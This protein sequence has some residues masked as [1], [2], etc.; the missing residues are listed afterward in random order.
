[1]CNGS[2]GPPMSSTRPKLPRGVDIFL[3]SELMLPMFLQPSLQGLGC[4]QHPSSASVYPWGPLLEKKQ[5]FPCWGGGDGARSRRVQEIAAHS[6][7]LSHVWRPLV[8]GWLPGL[9]AASD[10]SDAR[11][12]IEMHCMLQICLFPRKVQGKLPRTFPFRVMPLHSFL[13]AFKL[14]GGQ[15]G[16]WEFA[17]MH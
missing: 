17:F 8:P 14:E 5:L 9:Q 1:M 3:T 11:L 7:P 4:P 2:S 13:E 6:G 15:R 10:R 12:L 16:P